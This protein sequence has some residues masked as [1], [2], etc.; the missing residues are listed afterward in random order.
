MFCKNCGRQLD[1]GAAFCTGC[2]APAA[3]STQPQTQP[4]PLYVQPQVVYVQKPKTPGRGFGITSMVLGI[5]GGFYSIGGIAA[6]AE[7]SNRNH[8]YFE[9]NTNADLTGVA[10]VLLILALLSVI[11]AICAFA[12]NYKRGQSISGLI[13]GIITLIISV[14]CFTAA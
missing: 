9:A 6:F 1:D 8:S 4:Q 10:V 11:F 5:I 7:V 12:R 3:P 13:L 14:L 2:G